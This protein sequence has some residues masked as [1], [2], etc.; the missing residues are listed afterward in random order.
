MNLQFVF[1]L[2]RGEDSDRFCTLCFRFDRSNQFL[3]VT[4]TDLISMNLRL[5]CIKTFFGIFSVLMIT[6]IL[7]GQAIQVKRNQVQP[8]RT[9]GKLK[10]NFFPT[11]SC[12]L[13]F[14]ENSIWKTK[15]SVSFRK[16][17]I[18]F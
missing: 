4:S 8:P 13:S 14:N 7:S 15:N 2:L 12:Y 18:R 17:K 11:I 1:I 5:K 6:I 9:G 10:L 3:Y 16:R